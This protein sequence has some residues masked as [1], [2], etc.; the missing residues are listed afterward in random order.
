MDG[1]VRMALIT[2][3]PEMR[4][5]ALEKI[6]HYINTIDENGYIGIYTEDSRFQQGHESGELWAQSAI[7]RT[8]TAYYE[9]TGQKDILDIIIKSAELTMENY[10]QGKS[11]PFSADNEPEG[12][13]CGGLSH[14]LTI[15][16][17]FYFLYKETGDKRYIDY[18]VWL[19]ESCSSEPIFHSDIPLP[20]MLDDGYKLKYH[21]V[22]TYEHL[23]ALALA[24]YFGGKA[25]F[26]KGYENYLK[27]LAPCICPSGG[28]TGDEWINEHYA[29]ATKYGY[30]YCSIHELLHSYC[31]LMELSG[32]ISYADEIE[33][34]FYNAAL[35]AHHPSESS[36]TYLKSDNSY[37]MR[38]VFQFDEKNQE[39]YV[40]YGYKYSPTHQD[41]AVCCVPNA[42]RVFPY[43]Y[44]YMW[45]K[46]ETGF[47]KTMYGSSVL[48]D[49][50]G[51]TNVTI[52]EE[53]S[54]PYSGELK[55]NVKAE[56][57]VVM[58]LSFRIPSWCQ[59]FSVSADYKQEGS[60]ISIN[61]EWSDDTVE[62]NFHFSVTK[63]SDLLGDV[64]F[65]N[66][67]LVMALPIEDTES[68][69]REYP[70]GN[71]F[72]KEYEPVDK[73]FLDLAVF[74]D[75]DLKT[76]G[77]DISVLVKNIKTEEIERKT[78]VPMGKTNLRRVTF[79]TV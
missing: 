28:P 74:G 5:K 79:K 21:G 55:F 60:V 14:G 56:K 73:S 43:F 36:I 26:T 71:F 17:T 38:S 59:S 50:F 30:E 20:R 76:H 23:R 34:L 78:F 10:P 52:T 49:E 69:V 24:R 62:I 45:N 1:F 18:A 4:E 75:G 19:Y 57:P 65:T 16:D 77:E 67:P 25:E 3:V 8:L 58:T 13:S 32:D 22:H 39:G 31:L 7:L 29:D 70:I 61:K 68:V 35:G 9:V 27:K 44:G 41:M 6:N 15:V 51:G 12:T 11:R 2:D 33:K 47:I 37:A 53:S 72:D 63:H 54:Y 40:H 66:G 48:N 64:Y 42:C 46:T